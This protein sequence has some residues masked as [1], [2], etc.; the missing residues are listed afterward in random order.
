MRP[1]KL[2]EHTS[3]VGLE[4]RGRDPRALFSN[5]AQGLLALMDKRG[6]VRADKKVAIRV[7]ASSPET[8]LL[9]WLSELVFL[10]QTKRWLFAKVDFS[11]LQE[12]SLTATLHGEP[13]KDGVHRLGREVKAVTYHDLSIVRDKDAL[14]ATVLFD[15]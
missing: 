14:K 4:V 3:E 13:M 5:A 8:L 7:R 15:V 6:K 2:L 1:F 11:K 10:V 12:T 9:H